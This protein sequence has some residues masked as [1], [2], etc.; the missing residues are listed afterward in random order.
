VLLADTGDIGGLASVALLGGA[1]IEYLMDAEGRRIAR[2]RDGQ[3]TQALLYGR[4]SAPLA[5]LSA[6]GGVRTRFVYAT[7]TNVPDYLVRDGHTYRVLTDQLGSPR[8]VVDADTGAVA[9][10]LDFDEFGRVTRDTNPGFQPFGYAGGL[11]DPD[12]GLVR[13]GA[14]DYDAET[15]RWTAKD[16]IGFAGGDTNLYGYVIN[17]PVNLADPSGLCFGLGH[18]PVIDDAADKAKEVAGK[19]VDAAGDVATYTS[20][21]SAGFIDSW[22]FGGA[23]KLFGIDQWC[24]APGYGTGGVLGDLNP[25]GLGKTLVRGGVRSF[26]DD[27]GR[28]APD[29]AHNA[30]PKKVVVRDGKIVQPAKPPTR[31]Q[32]GDAGQQR[33]DDAVFNEKLNSPTS[34]GDTTGAVARALDRIMD[35][36]LDY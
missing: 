32:I 21:A 19:A 4:G 11:Y 17:D 23:S 20:N 5:E 6:T 16:P 12:T 13:F 14:R 28:Y 8:V 22:T 25:K 7:R 1:E 35:L 24:G 3:L 2:K 34:R 26:A 33:R 27:A 10:E 15:G 9:Q 31:T 30:I 36:D 18:C 29:L